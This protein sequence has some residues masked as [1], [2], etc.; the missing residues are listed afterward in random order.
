MKPFQVPSPPTV[1]ESIPID[2]TAKLF[3][4]PTIVGGLFE[5]SCAED[6]ASYFT[7]YVARKLINFHIK[8]LNIK[9]DECS[10]C[11]NILVSEDWCL[12]LFVSFKQYREN[13][14]PS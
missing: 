10:A 14:D 5:S 3:C 4:G 12:H 8:K 13:V 7:G 11:D 1:P 6:A 9:M 2:E